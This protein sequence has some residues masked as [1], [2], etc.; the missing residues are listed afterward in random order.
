MKYPYLIFLVLYCT[1]NSGAQNKQDYIWFFGSDQNISEEGI[2]ALRF[3]FNE[4]PF[5]PKALNNGLEFDSNNA[6]ICDHNGKLLFYTNGCA[7]SNAEHEIMM[8]GDSLNSGPFFDSFWLGDCGN[9]YPGRQDVLILNDPAY[10]KGYYLIHKTREY[11]PNSDPITYIKYLKYT[12]IDMNLDNG[13]GAVTQ[14]NI[15]FFESRF[16]WSYLTGIQHINGKDWWVVQPKDSEE[17]IFYTI[18]LTENGFEVTDSIQLLDEP[19]VEN[20]SAAGDAKFS[21]DG[22]TYIYSNLYDDLNVFDFD[23]ETGVLNN[24]RSLALKDELKFSSVEFSP[25]SRFVYLSNTDTLFQ[26]D[27]WEQNLED[28]KILIDIYDGVPDPFATTFF[29]STLAPDC[30]IYIRPGSGSNIMHVINKPNE[31]GLAC[32]FVERGLRLPQVSSTGGF[33]NFPR[34]RVD[35]AEKCDS[36]ITTMFGE[37][38]YY[39]RELTLFPNPTSDVFNIRIPDNEK[40]T[41]FFFDLHG[42]EVLSR[43][44]VDRGAIIMQDVSSWPVGTYNIEFIPDDNKKRLFWSGLV[45]KI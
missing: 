27:L 17:T 26:V 10:E 12:Y 7:I 37:L 28:G 3:D 5:E 6:S 39:R 13:F 18:L 1:V 38:V 33:P 11:D 19:F 42:Q 9:G 16:L 4:L 8:N 21:P 15:P 24:K 44:P 22:R 32:D 2:Q 30:K 25:N 40:G 35:E 45:Q 34:Y 20:S 29:L 14:K 43:R 23:R 31:K 41:L 36:S